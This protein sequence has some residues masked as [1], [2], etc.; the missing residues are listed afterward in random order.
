MINPLDPTAFETG[1]KAY[2]DARFAALDITVPTVT[3]EAAATLAA[4]QVYVGLSKEL[5]SISTVTVAL[6]ASIGDTEAGGWYQ[7][8]PMITVVTP[9]TVAG[10]E[11][12]HHQAVYAAIAQSFP[13][14]PMPGSVEDIE[15]WEELHAE[16]SEALEESC[17]YR[18]GG[19]FSRSSIYARREDR[20]EQPFVVRIGAV[21]ADA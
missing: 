2:L 16:L 10:L 21:H 11:I 18:A 20:I 19:W 17:G 9:I 8:E 14:R 3:G 5:V 6:R 13:A 4:P 1:L 12:S 15:D 7:I